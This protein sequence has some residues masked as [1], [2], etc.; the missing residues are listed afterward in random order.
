MYTPQIEDL[1]HV[2]NDIIDLGELLESDIFP[3]LSDDLVEAILTEA[4]RFAAQVIA[5][6]NRVGDEHGCQLDTDTHDVTTPPGWRKAYSQWAE[7]G[8]A[9]LPC[10][11]E[12]G[13]QGLPLLIGLAAQ[14]L[15]NTACGAYGIGTLLT[16]G[17]VNAISAHGT[18]ELKQTYLPNMVS[19]QWTGT[20][21]LTEAQAGSDLGALR[22]RAQPNGD[23]SYAISGTKI[24]ITYG[25]HQLTENIIH[26]V[27]ARLPDAPEGYRGI[28]LFLV[29]KFLLDE[30]GTP[31]ARNDVKC[32]GLEH[33]MGIHGSPT[34]TMQFGDEGGATG[35]LIGEENRGLNCMFTMMNDA[36][37]HVGVQGVAIAERAFQQALAYANERQQGH[38]AGIE[39]SVPIIE[40]ADVR[41]MLLEMKSKI[42]AAR[43]ISYQCAKALTL[44]EHAGDEQSRAENAAL[45]ALLTPVAKAFGSDIGTEVASLGVQ[46]HGGM[47]YIEETGAA[48]H[49]RDV[50][51]AQ[52]YE[53]TNGIQALDLVGRKLPLGNGQVVRDWLTAQQKIASG[54]DGDLADVGK[55]LTIA[56]NDLTTATQI[57]L[58]RQTAKDDCA[59]AAATKYLR[60]FALVAGTA[61]LAR[62]ARKTGDAKRKNLVIY[63]ATNQLPKVDALLDAIEHGAQSIIE[64]QDDPLSQ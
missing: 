45:G 14:E 1:K 16:Q 40:H 9:A 49:L 58:E 30:D 52:I 2:F 4:G 12:Y 17:A 3:D 39:G 38:R 50:R 27:L 7:G 19:G 64:R 21:C 60:A 25:E 20:M 55:R 15:W 5:P 11:Q 56:I 8:W 53:G 46:V 28:S 32:V 22:A 48:Q 54:L 10:K 26:L 47:G 62:G 23:G 24:F 63:F 51:I 57:E 33:K 44:A 31:G 34:A 13:G 29:P 59:A 37:I 36:R 41:D 35:W 43:A 18:D 61:A 6:L 42:A